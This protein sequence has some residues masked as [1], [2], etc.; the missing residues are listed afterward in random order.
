MQPVYLD[1]ESAV[2]DALPVDE[3]EKSLEVSKGDAMGVFRVQQVET[4]FDLESDTVLTL[5][6][7]AIKQK[8]LP[9]QEASFDRHSSFQ[10]FR[11][12]LN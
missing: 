9:S 4:E 3:R 10:S 6:S 11:C 5:A 2:A 1:R 12:S 8:G 7:L